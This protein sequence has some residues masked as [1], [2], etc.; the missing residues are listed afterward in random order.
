MI[1]TATRSGK[2]QVSVIY[3][4]SFPTLSTRRKARPPPLSRP[5]PPGHTLWMPWA[6]TA[7]AS[8]PTMS[9]L[10]SAKHSL[11]GYIEHRRYEHHKQHGD[12]R[13]RYGTEWNHHAASWPI[14]R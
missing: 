8:P 11:D 14:P 5:L 4:H 2:R 9:W 1:T 7:V 3:C 12:H 10:S 6:S 13:I